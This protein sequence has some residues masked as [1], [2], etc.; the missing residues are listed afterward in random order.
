MPDHVSLSN[1]IC[2][3]RRFSRH[4]AIPTIATTDDTISFDGIRLFRGT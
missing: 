4:T 1:L 2:Q 3:R